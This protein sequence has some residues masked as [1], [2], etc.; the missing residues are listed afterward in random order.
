HLLQ[1]EG[2]FIAAFQ[3]QVSDEPAGISSG[4]KEKAQKIPDELSDWL[5]T[6]EVAFK[7]DRDEWIAILPQHE[8]D[9]Q[10]LSRQL[11][12]YKP[13]VRLGKFAGKDFIPHHELAQSLLLSPKIERHELDLETAIRYLRKE[14]IQL[15]S[16]K[17]GWSLATYNSNGL[18][19]MKILPN[20]V[21]N[22]YP[23]EIRILKQIPEF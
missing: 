10:Y 15:N 13:G 4:K 6:K 17:K 16:A 7:T 23:K 20:R 19:W 11:H 18:G 12:F 1:G 9:W 3:K 8:P 5:N 14:N 2:F 22:Y 21:N